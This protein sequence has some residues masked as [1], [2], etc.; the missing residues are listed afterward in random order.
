MRNGY[1]I[2]ILDTTRYRSFNPAPNLH[3]L[4]EAQ[5]LKVLYK[6]EGITGIFEHICGSGK[7]ARQI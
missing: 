3:A 1:P 7:P 6:L 5:D 4:A 2:A